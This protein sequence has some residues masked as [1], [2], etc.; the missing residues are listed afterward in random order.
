MTCL[1]KAEIQ[2]HQQDANTARL[3]ECSAGYSIMFTSVNF[4]GSLTNKVL[5]QAAWKYLNP[6]QES[7][8]IPD[9]NGD[10]QAEALT[11]IYEQVLL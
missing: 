1:K 9:S 6:N 2:L 5:E 7:A 10:N 4:L 8:V 11:A 3:E